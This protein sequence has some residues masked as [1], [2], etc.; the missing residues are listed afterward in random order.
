MFTNRGGLMTT[1]KVKFYKNKVQ[2]ENQF[3]GIVGR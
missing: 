1:E 2:A 3:I